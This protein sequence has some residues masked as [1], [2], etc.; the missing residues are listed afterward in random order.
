[1]L[2]KCLYLTIIIY[3]LFMFTKRT[4]ISVCIFLSGCSASSPSVSS[5]DALKSIPSG[6]SYD[7]AVAKPSFLGWNTSVVDKYSCSLYSKMNCVAYS[8]AEQVQLICEGIDPNDANGVPSGCSHYAGDGY[9]NRLHDFLAGGIL[10]TRDYSCGTVG[11][12]NC[13]YYLHPG[14][15]CNDTNGS[16]LD[17]C[18]VNEDDRFYEELR[19]Q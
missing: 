2:E 8:Y 9:T 11:A 1:V 13:H 5:Q 18:G 16:A 6:C 10:Y 4:A 3:N 15:A 14:D 19:C 17:D 7:Q 12:L